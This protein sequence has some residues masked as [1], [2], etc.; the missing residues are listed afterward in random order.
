MLRGATL[1]LVA[2][3]ALAL[4]ACGSGATATPVPEAKT[5]AST[6]AETGGGKPVARL[7]KRP[8]CRSA[9]GLA[10]KYYRRC[11]M[12]CPNCH[13]DNVEGA[14]FC[15]SCGSSLSSPSVPVVQLVTL[16]GRGHRLG[17]AIIDGTIY[18]VAGILLLLII[19]WLLLVNPPLS[20][21]IFLVLVG[22]AFVTLLIFDMVLLTKDGQT[23]GKKLLGIR[24]VQSDTGEN[25]GFFPNVLLRLIFSGLLSIIPFY[26]LVDILFI[27]RGDRR[28]IHDMIA[29]T[30]VVEE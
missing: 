2:A 8:V 14:A 9:D 23:L 1:V 7:T 21:V 25:G 24:I 15:T 30:Q 17:A 12:E 29:G 26:G 28:C 20:A 27:F 11:T 16:A 22:L 10:L 3:A 19:F 18:L 13:T 5:E 4:A 6:A